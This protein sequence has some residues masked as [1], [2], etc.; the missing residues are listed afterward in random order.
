M[1][2][3]FRLYEKFLKSSLKVIL[4]VRLSVCLTKYHTMKTYLFAYL[5]T[6]S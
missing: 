6:A 1:L 3:G 2:V 4:K 5:S